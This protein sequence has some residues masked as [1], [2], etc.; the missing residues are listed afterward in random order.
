VVVGVSDYQD[1]RIPALQYADRDALAF[2]DFLL[3]ERAGMGGFQE[4][5][6]VLLLNDQAT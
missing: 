4:D 5:N 3:S 6:V 1:D 2:H